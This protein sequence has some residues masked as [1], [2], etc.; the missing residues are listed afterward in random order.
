MKVS[1][2]GQNENYIVIS[3]DKI[4][5]ENLSNSQ[6]WRLAD[7]IMNEPKSRQ[8]T[9]TEWVSKKKASGE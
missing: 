4:I 2:E 7:K 5:A 8:E 1:V 3:D 9:V 6:A